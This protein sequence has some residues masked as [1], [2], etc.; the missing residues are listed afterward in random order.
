MD[1]FIFLIFVAIFFGKPILKILNKTS[2][3]QKKAQSA[4]SGSDANSPWQYDQGSND[5]DGIY[6]ESYASSELTNQIAMAAARTKI[7]AQQRDRG[8]MAAPY[9][10]KASLK[11]KD[12]LK[13]KT[14]RPRPVLQDMNRQRVKGLS[15]Y[16]RNSLFEGPEFFAGLTLIALAFY[17]FSLIGS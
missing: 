15:R 7:N 16:K 4:L 6:E 14:S 11:S 9:S 13:I 2:E 1:F 17:L 12:S 3:V 8:S 10:A 5:T